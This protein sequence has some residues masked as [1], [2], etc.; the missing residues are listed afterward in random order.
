MSIYE[1]PER[2]KLEETKS[3]ITNTNVMLLNHMKTLLK[4]NFDMVWNNPDLSAQE[5]LDSFGSDAVTLFSDSYKLQVVI[6]EIDPSYN[7]LSPSVK[8]TIN[9][10]GTVT[11][12]GK[13]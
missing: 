11:I 5:V 2:N 6:K 10:D 1:T 4:N 7:V 12:G 13:I 8:Y 3:I 9:E